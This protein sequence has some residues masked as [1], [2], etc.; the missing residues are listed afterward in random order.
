MDFAVTMLL[1]AVLFAVAGMLLG[2]IIRQRFH[3]LIKYMR[4]RHPNLPSKF[5]VGNTHY[6]PLLAASLRFRYFAQGEFA[7]THDREVISRG[8]GIVRWTVA[9]VTALLCSV[10]AG[11]I[12][13][14]HSVTV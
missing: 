12:A 14:A 7:E 8:R 5:G 1:T 10:I 3:S 2:V 6:G 9:C 13:Y 4:R 11:V